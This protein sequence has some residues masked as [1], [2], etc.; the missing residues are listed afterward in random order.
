MSAAE[1]QAAIISLASLLPAQVRLA[2]LIAVMPVHVNLLTM[3]GTNICFAQGG[4]PDLTC[5]TETAPTAENILTAQ[6]VVEKW[7]EATPI[8]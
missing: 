1:I 3:D 5:I 6:Q 7:I 4:K 2:L 8:E